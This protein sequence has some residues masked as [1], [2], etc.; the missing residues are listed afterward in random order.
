MPSVNGWKTDDILTSSLFGLGTSRNKAAEDKFHDYAAKLSERGP[1]DPEVQNLRNEVAKIFEIPRMSVD[2][3]TDRL[4]DEFIRARL[5]T[6]SKESVDRIV[7]RASLLL[8]K[9]E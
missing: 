1:L 7:A 6:E 2:G 5:S 8:G 9:P 3:K 4:L